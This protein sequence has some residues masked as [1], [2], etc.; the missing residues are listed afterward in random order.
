MNN[1][2]YFC[3]RRHVQNNPDLQLSDDFLKSLPSLKRIHADNRT[4]GNFPPHLFNTSS[5]VIIPVR[6]RIH[7]RLHTTPAEQCSN[8]DIPKCDDL[9]HLR[10]QNLLQKSQT[11][12]HECV[13]ARCN[14]KDTGGQ[15]LCLVS[16]GQNS[17]A[18]EGLIGQ[19]TGVKLTLWTFGLLAVTSNL[20]VLVTLLCNWEARRSPLC[21]FVMNLLLGNVLIGTHIVIVTVADTVT[22]GD[23]TQGCPEQLWGSSLCASVFVVKNVGLVI[24]VLSLV[25]LAVERFVANFFKDPHQIDS[26]K[27]VGYVIECWLFAAI[28]TIV[29]WTKAGSWGYFCST[30]ANGPTFADIDTGVK[31]SLVG[32]CAVLIFFYVFLLCR[33]RRKAHALTRHVNSHGEYR[34]TVRM[35]LL[36]MATVGSWVVPYTV[37]LLIVPSVVSETSSMQIMAIALSLNACLHTFIF[38]YD[39]ED[40]DNLYAFLS[41]RWEGCALVPQDEFY[42]EGSKTKGTD[43]E[44]SPL[45]LK[46]SL[47]L[48][49]SADVKKSSMSEVSAEERRRSGRGFEVSKS[50][51]AVIITNK[52]PTTFRRDEETTVL[53]HSAP[54]S[55][56]TLTRSS[57]TH[58]EHISECGTMSSDTNVTWVSS[59]DCHS[60][61]PHSPN[62]HSRFGDGHSTVS[63]RTS[64]VHTTRSASDRQGRKCL[65]TVTSVSSRDDLGPSDM[66]N[67]TNG[68]CGGGMS[69]RPGDIEDITV[70]RFVTDENQN[71]RKEP[72]TSPMS[73]V[74]DMLARVLSPRTKKR[75]KTLDALPVVEPGNGPP[76]QKRSKS[77]LEGKDASSVHVREDVLESIPPIRFRE[78]K[79]KTCARDKR[80]GVLLF[81]AGQDGLEIHEGDSSVE[82]DKAGERENKDGEKKEVRPANL[83]SKNHRD[84]ERLATFLVIRP[85]SPSSKL[86]VNAKTPK[87]PKKDEQGNVKIYANPAA[88]LTS[89]RSEEAADCTVHRPESPTKRLV[90]LEEADVLSA[91]P[92]H[93]KNKRPNSVASTSSSSRL[94]KGSLDWDP[95]CTGESYVDDDVMPPTP[96]PPPKGKTVEMPAS[97]PASPS[98]SLKR[99][100]HVGSVQ[101]RLDPTSRYSLE[102]DPTGVQ[103]RLSVVSQDT[104]E[105]EVEDSVGEPEDIV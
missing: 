101:V 72:R 67:G 78:K 75:P 73:P 32:I 55:P 54:S 90:K 100:G 79:N 17:T 94:S 56:S 99:D 68:P 3:P 66:T 58:D 22:Y 83:G 41:C 89:V 104:K 76:K 28:A 42:A 52:S 37:L 24:V 102:W 70:E 20:L 19:N 88:S 46:T 86:K 25:L 16:H 7:C 95:T 71:A 9:K 105:E 91:L 15:D 27:A 74:R 81:R 39:N 12:P 48:I 4:L 45:H 82:T 69:E 38:S 30:Y 92:N 36:L 13:L 80:N 97:P 35:F 1:S 40:L 34:T 98:P 49:S 62:S 6:E 57:R 87:W 93:L 43:F 96:P 14:N 23:V 77:M 26:C 11:S 33:L 50:Q 31:C 59:S 47:D 63:S 29:L 10:G 5:T 85:L 53:L 21:I 84:W 103:M 60:S 51:G 65:S 8:L 44:M 61:L 64:S 18:C 2:L